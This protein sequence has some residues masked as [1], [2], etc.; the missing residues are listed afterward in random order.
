MDNKHELNEIITQ[1]LKEE[2]V[3]GKDFE[4]LSKKCKMNINDVFDNVAIIIADK[5]MQNEIDFEKADDAM[6]TVWIAMCSYMS[7]ITVDRM[8]DIAY[9]I[10]CAFDGG[11]STR[12][13]GLDPVELITKPELREIFKNLGYI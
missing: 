4:I 12:S 7:G 2:N 3:S 1:I 5:F 11:E 10:Y 9:S 13:D 6:N 8:A